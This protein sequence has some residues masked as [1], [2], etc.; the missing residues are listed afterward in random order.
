[1]SENGVVLIAEAVHRIVVV[2]KNDAF[3]KEEMG[4]LKKIIDTLQRI[5][6]KTLAEGPGEK[7][8]LTELQVTT[9]RPIKCG[10]A[11]HCY[12]HGGRQCCCLADDKHGQNAVAIEDLTGSEALLNPGTGQVCNAKEGKHEKED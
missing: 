12:E 1:M 9:P 11:L 7:E 8:C 2:L 10:D 6:D 5:T 4:K 3:T